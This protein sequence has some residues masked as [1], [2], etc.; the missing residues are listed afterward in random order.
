MARLSL[1]L[2]KA[3]LAPSHRWRQPRRCRI[4]RNL[5]KEMSRSVLFAE[6]RVNSDGLDAGTLSAQVVSSTTRARDACSTLVLA[7]VFPQLTLC[8][9]FLAPAV[10]EASVRTASLEEPTNPSKMRPPTLT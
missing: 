1:T 4:H 10:G 7:S 5:V 3:C 8:G 9:R 6:T 2:T